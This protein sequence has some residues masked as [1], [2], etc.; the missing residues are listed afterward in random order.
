MSKRD[1]LRRRR[2][3]RTP[4]PRILI[5]SEGEVT[6]PEYFNAMRR[7]ERREVALDFKSGM[8]PKTAVEAAARMKRDYDE[9]WC[10]FDIDV[11]PLVP[12]AK[13]QARD[14]NIELA[15]SN[16]CFELWALLHYQDQRAHIELPKL[17][18]LCRRHM[19]D[20]EKQL[21]FDEMFPRIE[22][23]IRRAEELEKMHA[24]RGTAGENPS[25][26]VYRLVRSIRSR[27]PSLER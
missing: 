16:P 15:I 20:Y 2:P 11:H 26:G 13:Q 22:E 8:T 24:D 19:R 4:Y 12:D 5:V 1:S 23:A 9:V 10:V 27:R 6:E 7:V 3:T 25:T 18:E 17:R 21:P 14:N